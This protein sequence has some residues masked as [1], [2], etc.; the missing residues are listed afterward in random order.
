MKSVLTQCSVIK[1]LMFNA[2]QSDDTIPHYSNIVSY[3]I[4]LNYRL[5]SAP[6][7]LVPPLLDDTQLQAITAVYT[8]LH[9]GFHDENDTRTLLHTALRRLLIYE[10]TAE[11]TDVSSDPVTMSLVWLNWG[12]DGSFQKAS[13][14]TQTF[15]A[16]QFVAR[17]TV[18][19]HVYTVHKANKTNYY[20]CV[21]LRLLLLLWLLL[22]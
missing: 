1:P 14:I 16:V 2:P 18:L 21:S 8:A 15:A 9:Q 19:V 17:S 12:K 3:I 10:F 4:I 6:K 22:T 11:Q 20:R 7:P 13:D 5:A